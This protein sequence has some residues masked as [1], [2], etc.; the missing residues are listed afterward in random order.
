MIQR[1]LQQLVKLRNQADK[2]LCEF[3]L[4]QHLSSSTPE[5]Y[6]RRK[7]IEKLD[8]AIRELGGISAFH[9]DF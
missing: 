1:M 2:D 5:H 3:L 8:D 7:L 4:Q 6:M 9:P